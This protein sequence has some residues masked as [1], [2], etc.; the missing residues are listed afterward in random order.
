MYALETGFYQNWR[1]V[2]VLYLVCV[3]WRLTV[4]YGDSSEACARPVCRVCGRDFQQ[5]K[6]YKLNLFS[7]ANLGTS[8]ALILDQKVE[9][10]DGLPGIFVRSV[11]AK[12][13]DVSETTECVT[14]SF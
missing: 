11:L 12:S 1:V 6:K 8:L 14:P 9:P 5:T 10:R 7:S 4:Y 2:F 13:K 3:A